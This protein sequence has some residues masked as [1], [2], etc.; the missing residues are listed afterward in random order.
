[1]R[2]RPSSVVHAGD[3]DW[4]VCGGGDLVMRESEKRES[5]FIFIA[6]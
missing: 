1:M 6:A 4:L 5:A 3:S 2:R